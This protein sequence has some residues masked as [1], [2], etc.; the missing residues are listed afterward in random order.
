M[1]ASAGVVCGTQRQ[2]KRH[3]R[4][5]SLDHRPPSSVPVHQFARAAAADHNRG[6]I[7]C[8]SRYSVPRRQDSSVFPRIS[9]LP[10]ASDR[11][12][13]GIADLQINVQDEIADLLHP[14]DRRQLCAD[15]ARQLELAA[16]AVAQG[17]DLGHGLGDRAPCRPARKPASARRCR[18][19]SST[20]FSRAVSSGCVGSMPV[21]TSSKGNRASVSPAATG[22]ATSSSSTAEARSQPD[23]LAPLAR[24]D[25][26]KNGPGAIDAGSADRDDLRSVRQLEDRQLAAEL[27]VVGE[28]R[29]RHPRRRGPRCSTVLSASSLD[30]RPW[31]TAPCQAAAFSC[32]IRPGRQGRCRPSRRRPTARRHTA[33]PCASRC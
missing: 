13:A 6:R 3:E 27:R 30:S 15:A 19:I 31:S 26:Q 28:R 7:R 22:A 33:C 4:G 29:C 25:A 24:R 14:A 23:H 18:V 8:F 17:A 2:D 9:T 21:L 10:S 16:V 32:W 1:M 11:A 5:R 12:A 20:V